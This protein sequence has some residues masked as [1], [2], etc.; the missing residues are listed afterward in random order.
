MTSSARRWCL[1]CAAVLV[2]ITSVPYLVG[3]SVAGDAWGFSGFVFGVEDG[4]SYIAKMRSGAE[5]AWLF[6][7]PYTTEL[8]RGVIAFL[9]YLL[10]G[11]LASPPA[12][13]EQ[14]VALFQVARILVIPLEVLATYQFAA[15][16]LDEEK[17]RR[18]AV[19]MATAGGG[20][21]WLLLA[22]G[23]GSWLGSLPLDLH[24]PESF[25]FLAIY[26]IPHLVLGR[27][28]LLWGLARYLRALVHPR[29]A[30]VGGALWLALGLVQPLQLASGYAAVLAH[31]VALAIRAR[32]RRDATDLRPWIGAVGR[33]VVVSSGAMIYTAVAF[34][35]DPYLRAWTE[36]NRIL[37]PHPLHYLAAY[38]LVAIP[39]V[40]GARWVIRQLPHRGLLLAGWAASLPVLA[41][42]PVNV[43]RRLPEGIWV[44]VCILAAAGL[45]GLRSTHSV[46]R[47]WATA[48]LAASLPSTLVLLAGGLWTAARPAPP[49]FLPAAEV[50]A[51]EWFEANAEP[52]SVVLASY[53]ASN[54]LPAWAPVRVVAG[55][56]PESASLDELLPQVEAFYGGESSDRQR[57]DFLRSQRVD[58]VFYGP[59]ERSLGDWDPVGSEFLQH[60]AGFDSYDL[61][62]VQAG[63]G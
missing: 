44:A 19:V 13:H 47:R 11:K 22:L 4:N 49:A 24:S 12:M 57:I 51:L 53:S 32:V 43:Q 61:Y 41:Y 15:F 58:Y 48:L 2:L 54:A 18:W 23:Q 52:G 60:V 1:G 3:F 63:G 38:G 55:H 50:E 46:S 7:T 37:S 20:L 39:A 25:G 45:G 56:G 36:Q 35:G 42:V 59:E 34:S 6:Q 17:W 28:L 62:R 14:L 30:W 27:A 21:G 16:F 29:A 33:M 10:L 9:P 5:G 26:G 40:V 31:G 8:Q